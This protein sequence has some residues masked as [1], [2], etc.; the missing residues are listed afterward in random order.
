MK[1]FLKVF[2]VLILA[3]GVVFG[4]YRYTN[5]AAF[6]NKSSMELTTVSKP[7]ATE[8]NSNRVLLA[9]LEEEEFYLY[10]GSIGVLLKHGNNE[11]TF[12]N[13]SKSIDAEAPE[14]RFADF[15][16]DGKKELAI[17]AVSEE[18]ENGGFIY[19]IYILTPK[20]DSEGKESFDVALASRNT[21]TSILENNIT[22]EM[23]QLK[24]CKKII[25]F[26][27]IS[28][29]KSLTYNKETGIATN[30]YSGYARA[31]QDKSGQYLTVSQWAKGDGIYSISNDNKICIS[32]NINISYNNSSTLQN[33]GVIYFELFLNEENKFQVTEKTMVFKPNNEYRVSDPTKTATESWSFEEN[34]SNKSA[35]ASS[36]VIQWIKYSPEYSADTFAQTQDYS[37]Q[38]SDINKIKKIYICESYAILS[39][40]QGYT[41]DESAIKSGEYS[42]VINDDIDISYTAELTN[43]GG[44]QAIKI[45]FDKA[46]PQS[47]IN[48]ITFNYGTK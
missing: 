26:S 41:F 33:A 38:I 39:A 9:S 35:S 14:M 23:R 29:G 19:D 34:N 7:A 8:K 15:N 30:G 31:L 20:T 32:I 5:P 3:V 40:K 13:W 22:E 28:K 1:Y 18:K 10:K 45:T 4:V 43:T 46:Y 11:F 24:N 2:I 36:G 47:E 44:V 27:M 16:N 6:Q 25:Q 21:W 42:V 12:T 37:S 17:K 48:K